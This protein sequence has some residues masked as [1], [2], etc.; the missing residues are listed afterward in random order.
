MA[1]CEWRWAR[2]AARHVHTSLYQHLSHQQRRYVQYCLLTEEPTC[3]LQRCAYLEE[4][5]DA[6]WPCA[7]WG[8]KDMEKSMLSPDCFCGKRLVK[9][10]K[11]KSTQVLVPHLN[12]SWYSTVVLWAN[13]H[14]TA[15]DHA[16]SCMQHVPPIH[17]T[18]ATEKH[19]FTSTL[20]T[21]SIA[22][23]WTIVLSMTQII[24]YALLPYVSSLPLLRSKDNNWP[25]HG[26]KTELGEIKGESWHYFL[27]FLVKLYL[28][29]PFCSFYMSA[30]YLFKW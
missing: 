6:P 16:T 29:F 19:L 15:I 11:R 24:L 23:L 25:I 21:P 7:M 2:L 1:M 22:I 27:S 18:H 17:S 3:E 20:D 14:D 9:V 5:E 28:F 13:R 4:E 10:K 8:W 26:V 30:K 12:W